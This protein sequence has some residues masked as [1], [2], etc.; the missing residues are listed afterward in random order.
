MSNIRELEVDYNALNMNVNVDMDSSD[1]TQKMSRHNQNSLCKIISIEAMG[2]LELLYR[3]Q[4]PWLST[5]DYQND[6]FEGLINMH[7]I[8]RNSLTVPSWDIVF[9]RVV[10]CEGYQILPAWA[11]TTKISL[12]NPSAHVNIN[13]K[14]EDVPSN[15]SLDITFTRI[16]REKYKKKP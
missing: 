9:I 3:S 8:Q 13:A 6:Q 16:D 2:I 4:W 15:C 11:Q 14:F 10:G 7:P 1:M 5:S 12:I